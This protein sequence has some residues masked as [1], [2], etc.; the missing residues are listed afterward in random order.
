MPDPIDHPEHYTFGTIEPID[1]IEDWRLGHHLACVVRYVCRAEHKGS[2]IDDLRKA[3]WYLAR[4]I[5]QLER[6]R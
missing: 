5:R 6:A 3:A 2:E 1:V 4:R